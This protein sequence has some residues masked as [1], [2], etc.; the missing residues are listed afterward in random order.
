MIRG[1]I[2]IGLAVLLALPLQAFSQQAD[3]GSQTVELDKLRTELRTLADNIRLGRAVQEFSEEF[4]LFDSR[5]Y[6]R[7][8]DNQD[9]QERMEQLSVD[10]NTN[11]QLIEQAR[12]QL[13]NRGDF[14]GS[15]IDEMT[16]AERDVLAAEMQ[17]LE[18]DVAVMENQIHTL[19]MMSLMPANS[20]L[21]DA[22]LWEVFPGY[23]STQDILEL[24]DNRLEL[25]A[26]AGRQVRE[27][28][29]RNK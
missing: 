17:Q 19:Q 7:V 10:I 3:R 21:L 9:R 8:I 27:V 23:G 29:A 22:S 5:L 13:D 28:R 16:Q 12:S 14:V 18:S 2:E 20:E 25:M 1:V 6:G 24:I 4:S 11:N 15:E 26:Q